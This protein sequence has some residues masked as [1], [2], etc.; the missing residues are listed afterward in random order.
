MTTDAREEFD[1]FRVVINH[2]EQYSIWPVYRENPPGWR[3]AGKEGSQEECLAYI[4][5]AWTDM[6][7]LSIRNRPTSFAGMPTTPPP[8]NGHLPQEDLVQR[9]S[10]GT[11]TVRATR[12]G[13]LDELDAALE[14]GFLHLTFGGTNGE[15]ELNLQV[16]PAATQRRESGGHLHVEGIL[17]LDFVPVRCVADLDLPALSGTGRLVMLPTAVE[18]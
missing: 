9:L 12:A 7:P 2:E 15:T 1:L 10:T 5:E 6:R 18:M 4:E 16:D 13:S 17:T 3:N 14:R 11:H 8:A